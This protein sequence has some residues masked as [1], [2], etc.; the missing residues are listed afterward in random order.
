MLRK[1]DNYTYNGIN[2]A[3]GRHALRMPL[4]QNA[5]RATL[6]R[7]YNAIDV[8]HAKYRIV[9]YY[10]DRTRRNARL[11]EFVIVYEIV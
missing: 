6:D 9:N 11:G 5:V 3:K 4:N 7:F 8:N 10:P 2:L 1:M